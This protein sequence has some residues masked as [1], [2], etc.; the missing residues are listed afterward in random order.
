MTATARWGALALLLAPVGAWSLGLGNIELRSALNQP[1]D[2]EIQLVSATPEE[3]ANLR[4]SLASPATFSRYGLDRPG[5]LGGLAFRL[6]T[7]DLGRPVILV[8]SQQAMIEPFVTM[9]VEVIWSRGRLLREYTVL[10]DPPVILPVPEVAQRIQPAEVS[11]PDVTQPAAAITRPAPEPVAPPTARAL[12]TSRVPPLQTFEPTRTPAPSLTAGRYGPVQSAETLWAITERYRPAG[13]TMNQMLVAFYRANVQAFGGNMNTLYEGATLRVPQ[14]AEVA[15][16]SAAA[17]TQEAI[18]QTE[19]WRQGSVEQQA[20]LR[21]VMPSGA[22]DT[23]ISATGSG[24]GAAAEVI[25]LEGELG[26]LRGELEDNR[27]LLEIRDQQLQELQAML[28]AA[29]ADQERLAEQVAAAVPELDVP[30][31]A[32]VDLESE[33]LFADEVEPLAETTPVIAEPA[34]IAPPAAASRVVTTP[35]QP[36]LV[37][38]IL[39]WLAGIPG[40]LTGILGSLLAI[41]GSAATGIL[42]WVTTPILLGGLGLGLVVV[43]GATVMYLRSR[44]GDIDAVTGHWETLDEDADDGGETGSA[45]ASLPQQVDSDAEDFLVADQ[46][47]EAADPEPL[48]EVQSEV[49]TA[50][51][52]ES[53]LAPEPEPEP[54]PASEVLSDSALRAA[55]PTVDRTRTIKKSEPEPAHDDTLSSQTLI[56]LEQ[57]DAIAEADFHLAYGLY[58]QAAELVEK[59]LQAEPGRRDLKLKLLEVFFVW[60]NKEFF[61]ETAQGLRADIGSGPDPEWDK[62][63][64]M[65]KQICP[66]DDLFSAATVSAGAEL[67]VALDAGDSPSLDMAFDADDAADVNL[68]EVDLG[69]QEVD[70]AL[71]GSDTPEDAAEEVLDLGAETLAGLETALFAQVKDDNDEATGKPGFDPDATD[72]AS[73]P[74]TDQGTAELKLDELGLDLEDLADLD[75]ENETPSGA[76][77]LEAVEPNTVVNDILSASADPSATDSGIDLDLDDLGS[78]PGE[79]PVAQTVGSDVMV[80]AETDLNLD[81]DTGT[82]AGDTSTSGQTGLL[83]PHSMTMTDVGTKLDLARAYVDMGDQDGAR[84]ILDEVLAEGDSTQHNEAQE[85]IDSL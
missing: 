85:I 16:V 13:V 82:A 75:S 9:L 64:I 30:A 3:L 74:E 19:L 18:R 28:T 56:N 67:D 43:V 57:A 60:G 35:T 20:R 26:S 69:N 77:D 78:E 14:L 27:R 38:R 62:V 29:A 66:D 10:L 39:G 80:G 24:A 68:G 1:L 52:S 6:G 61:L 83:D 11:A 31:G 37:S 70:L 5:Y 25:E 45:T 76:D 54:E 46:L 71:E 40:W 15:E 49:P 2:A 32:G 12:P 79:E 17:A 47:I 50:L 65:G 22:A 81:A 42:D 72:T 44:R 55:S 59:A 84:A 21:L 51:I 73:S 58:D 33:V 34:V 23:G 53:E 41:L 48:P 63:V 36:S 8:S 4:V 7:N